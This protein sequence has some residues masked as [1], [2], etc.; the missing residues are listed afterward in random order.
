[1]SVTDLLTA[2]HAALSPVTT[3]ATGSGRNDSID[4]RAEIVRTA[5][6]GP[7]GQSDRVRGGKG[8][9]GTVQ[10]TRSRLGRQRRRGS[11]R[12]RRRGAWSAQ[13]LRAHRCTW[14]HSGG[15]AHLCSGPSSDSKIE[16]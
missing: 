5:L 3:S 15:R 2:A 6:H 11:A 10:L 14:L 16:G 9:S 13:P 7:G 4:A 1:M 12:C 8:T